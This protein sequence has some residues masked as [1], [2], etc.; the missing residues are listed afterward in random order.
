MFRISYISLLTEAQI[1]WLSV[2]YKHLA[3][4]GA[5]LASYDDDFFGATP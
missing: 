5:I 3:P 2:S 1:N 4:R